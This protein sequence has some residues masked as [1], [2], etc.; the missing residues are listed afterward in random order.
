MNIRPTQASTSAQVRTGLLYNLNKLVT[1]QQQV[2][3]GKRILKPSDDPVGSSLAQSYRRALEGSG[4]Y[5]SAIESGRTMVDTAA[6]QLQDAAGLLSEAR[7]IVLQGMNGTQSSL[8][9]GLF[10]GEVALM[11]DRLM[12]IANAQI[13]N[14]FLF[15][16]TVTNAPPYAQESAGSKTVV[17]YNGNN[18]A[19]ELLV[20]R[21]TRVETTIPGK[22]VFS[23]SDPSGVR[24]SG[25]TGVAAGA[26]ANQGQGALNLDL[27]HDATTGTPG[28]GL[29]FANGGADDTILGDHTLVVD[30]AAGTVQLG[31]GPV[32]RFPV[33]G[34]PSEADFVVKSAGGA[35][36]HLDFTGF[37]G[38]DVN[39]V[40]RGDGS[41]SIDGASYTSLSFT[42]TDLQL[43]DPSTGAVLHVDTTGV[44]RAGPELVH[45]GGTVDAFQ[46]L[47]GIV[48]E[49]E[50]SKG[51]P[52]AEL[53]QRLQL[54]LGE[55]DRNHDSVLRATGSLGSRSQRLSRME[56][57]L[58]D[59]DVQVQSLLSSVEDAD[60]SQVVLDMTAAE[61]TLELA[62]A[63]SVR[64]LNTSLLNFLR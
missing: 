40:V 19:Q 20:G 64:L 3:T 27:R 33:P 50:N 5:R 57:G 26:S 59:S 22:D 46:T 38:V 45:F 48:D 56:S 13:G 10:A 29:A 63:T 42:E 44:G 28:A 23:A 16:G 15:G 11:R 49:L 7:A 37:T 4:R 52:T 32:V 12:D 30:A 58:A 39:S 1:A 47:Q 54:W 14:R 25:L 43:I 17:N 53:Q 36:L 2:A 62:Q 51:L 60:F 9:R 55:L 34:D 24:F 6:G 35:E 8:D 31:S 21:N 18:E 41:I 61:Q